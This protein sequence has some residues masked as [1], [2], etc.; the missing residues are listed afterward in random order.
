MKIVDKSGSHMTQRD[1]EIIKI[2]IK[3]GRVGKGFFG[4]KGSPNSYQITK[5]GK[6]KYEVVRQGVYRNDYG[7]RRVRKYKFKFRVEK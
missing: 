7:A 2:G 4:V 6:D 3:A 1:I 5:R